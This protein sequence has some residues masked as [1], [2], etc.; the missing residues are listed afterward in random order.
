MSQVSTII[1]LGELFIQSKSIEDHMAL[2]ELIKKKVS[3]IPPIF[4]QDLYKMFTRYS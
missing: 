4:A 1:N 2:V 3:F